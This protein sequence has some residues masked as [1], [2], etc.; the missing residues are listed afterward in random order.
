MRAF[1]N[2]SGK[3]LL[4][5]LLSLLIWTNWS[6][7]RAED[8]VLPPMVVTAT[9]AK[10]P[11][12][13]TSANMTLVSREQLER[14][15]ANNLGE[16][17]GLVPG[18]FADRNGD[19][20]SATT[21]SIYGS[22]ARHV[23]VYI[24]GV[25]QN[26]LANPI[27]DLSK[28]PVDRVERIEVYR[29]AA[30][31]AWG[32]A[33][34][35]VINIITRQATSSRVLS[36]KIDLSA[37]EHHTLG[38]KG[39]IQGRVGA[40]GYLLQSGQTTSAGFDRHREFRQNY[41][42]L[43]INHTTD[44]GGVLSFSA[45]MDRADKNDP[46]LKI[47]GRWEAQKMERA[48]QTLKWEAGEGDHLEYSLSLRRQALDLE[49]DFMFETGGRRRFFTYAE[50]TWGLSVQARINSRWSEERS[51]HLTVGLDGDWGE[52]NFSL[53]GR[54]LATR[55]LAAWVV[56]S[57][58]VGPWTINLGLRGDEHQDFGAVLSPS[59]GLVYRPSIIPG[60]WRF[61]VA[62]GFSAPPLTY[63]FD[64]RSGNPHLGPERVTDWQ[65]GLDLE[66]FKGWA[67]TIN[68]FRAD[69]EDMIYYDPGLG[70]FINLDQVQRQGVEIRTSIELPW[71]L[72]LSGG[73]TWL[74]VKDRRT[75]QKILDVPDRKYDWQMTYRWDNL[76]Q[77]LSGNWLDYN[78][79]QKDTRDK[80]FIIDYLARYRFSEALSAYVAIKNITDESEYHYWFLPHPGRQL[81][82]GLTWCF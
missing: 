23:A 63:L 54:D 34:G 81:Q 18:L 78:S 5:H 39:E 58:D 13:R 57:V 41:G 45:A 14:F 52:Y 35:G 7:V 17:L 66:F 55:N 67:G 1:M 8:L 59:A 71:G 37:G 2:F 36:G 42:Y 16:V 25:L 10:D 19:P 61:Q 77:S 56:E 29:G 46:N 28:I 43:K 68:L 6:I 21:V 64:P 33:L 20:G 30:S 26:M 48:Y 4:C 73:A 47:P 32:S 53:L 11:A 69:V 27:A 75:G 38:A 60:Q 79:G 12:N 40:T 9:R 70:Y 49:D 44:D 62:K 3:W 31:S 22:E 51:Q 72:T 80:C 65:L 82:G 15:P 50:R 24:D 74:E 76:T